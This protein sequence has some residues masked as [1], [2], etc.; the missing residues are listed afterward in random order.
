MAL[1]NQNLDLCVSF[2]DI[3]KL[4]YYESGLSITNFKE[5]LLTEFRLSSNTFKLIDIQKNAEITSEKLFKSEQE[6]RIELD[7]GNSSAINQQ[8]Q[9]PEENK[10]QEQDGI[11]GYDDIKDRLF[12]E[13]TLLES[14]NDWAATKKF[15]LWIA[16]GEKK[17][18]KAKTT[19]KMT[20]RCSIRPCKYRIMFK[21]N[22][23]GKNFQVYEKL[24]KK[25]TKHSN[26]SDYFPFIFFRS[27]F[28]L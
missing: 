28:R 21:S 13:G 18:D 1:Q 4:I 25:Y 26:N 20:F 7:L 5:Y 23:E 3:R 24:S 6:I 15:H 27:Y 8:S 19:Q 22:K 17:M 9:Q 16:E 10:I 11:I 14:L 2:G 12:D